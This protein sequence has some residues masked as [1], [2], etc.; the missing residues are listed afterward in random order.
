MITISSTFTTACARLNLQQNGLVFRFLTRFH[1][2][3]GH[4]SLRLER[5]YDSRSTNLWSARVNDELRTI[6]KKD[7]GTW[8]AVYVGLHDDAYH[9]A[10][11]HEVGRHPVTNHWQVVEMPVL[12]PPAAIPPSP[13]PIPILA[14]HSDQY[15]MSL[16]VPEAWLPVLRPIAVRAEFDRQVEEKLPLEVAVRLL[17]LVDGRAVELPRPIAPN[18]PIRELQALSQ[19]LVV[20]QNDQELELIL[21]EPMAKWIAFLHPSQKRLVTAESRGPVKITGSAGTGKTV[22]AMHRARQLAREGQRV[23]ITSFVQTICQNI[24][25]NLR[26]LCTDEE[27]EKISVIHVHRLASDILHRA[28][29]HWTA[30]SEN[31]LLEIIGSIDPGSTV[32]DC[33][34]GPEQLLIE[35]MTIVEHQGIETWADYRAANRAGRGRALTIRERRAV[36]TVLEQIRDRL[37]NEQFTTWEG[38]CRLAAAQ[39]PP[40]RSRPAEWRYDAVIVDE[41]QDLKPQELHLIARLAPVKNLF[42]AGDAGQKIYPG[43]VTLHT[44]GIDVRGRS[45]ILR[46]NYRTTEQIRLYADRLLDETADDLDGGIE[47]RR[48]TRSLLRGREPIVRAFDARK[49]QHDFVAA[50]IARLLANGF[51]PDSIGVFAR[52]SS[53]LEMLKT[54]F[55]RA[56]IPFFHLKKDE[57]PVEPAV[58]LGT[59]HRAKGLEFK[60]V[61]VVDLNDEN[62]PNRSAIEAK[63]DQ[64]VREEQLNL[65]RQLLYVS[66]TRARDLVYLTWAGAPSRFLALSS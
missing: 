53:N 48:L 19:D 8:I 51:T 62:M 21:K 24:E 34:L 13:G 39:L 6:I 2:D 37:R 17:D 54:R 36:W 66:V 20:V 31:E 59:M 63:V 43:R 10:A 45:T 5:L 44:M 1:D 33:P 30:I 61:F 41:L 15:L 28:N 49:D 65:E 47:N 16:G 27:M 32:P 58:N 14:P 11:S 22:V 50:E 57:F 52:Q 38:L 18:A 9:W 25:R 56:A 26:H 40:L 3:P 23:L 4:P 35:W 7:G 55:T 60:V 64:V 12:P 46:L 29:Q 42:L